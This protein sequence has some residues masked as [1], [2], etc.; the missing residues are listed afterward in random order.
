MSEEEDKPVDLVAEARRLRNRKKAERKRGALSPRVVDMDMY[1]RMRFE[2]EL[3]RAVAPFYDRE[4]SDGVLNEMQR[5]LKKVIGKYARTPNLGKK[6]RVFVTWTAE[7]ETVRIGYSF[8]GN[9]VDVYDV[10]DRIN[11]GSRKILGMHVGPQ[12]KHRAVT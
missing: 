1:R 8:E 11:P 2:A 4:P 12:G 3:R 7:D 10:Y 6:L 9:P 5:S